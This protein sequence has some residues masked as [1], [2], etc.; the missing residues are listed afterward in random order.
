MHKL[1][2]SLSNKNDLIAWQHRIISPS[3]SGQLTPE[4]FKK[5]EL[6]RSAVSGA[7]NLPYD[8]P[9]ILVD[10]V[11]T[12]T[13]VPVG[14]WRSVYNSQ[15]AFAN[16]VFIDELAHRAGTDALEFRMN[17]LHDSPRHKEALRLAAQKL[18]IATKF[19]C[20]RDYKN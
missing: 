3:I 6:D 19:V 11:M 12:N 14:W 2:A 7:S 1:K 9:N 18:P 15:N 17:M 10:Y 20:R 8:I 13:N 16:E 4:N 5:G